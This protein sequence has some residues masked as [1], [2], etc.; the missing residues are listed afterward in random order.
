M[1]LKKDFVDMERFHWASPHP[2]LRQVVPNGIST[3]Y[4]KGRFLFSGFG[5]E[6]YRVLKLL[7]LQK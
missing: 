7:A 4:V 3:C 2:G 5:G 6:I 1:C